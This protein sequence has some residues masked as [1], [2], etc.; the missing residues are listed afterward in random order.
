MEIKSRH[1]QIDLEDLIS[2]AEA[3]RIRAV[4]RAAISDL[5][6]RGR[7]GSVKIGGHL[8]LFRSEVEAFEDRRGWP[9]GKSRRSVNS[10]R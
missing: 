3:A 8:L 7:I 4:S 2:Q 6:K 5:V 1:K 9:K 10:G